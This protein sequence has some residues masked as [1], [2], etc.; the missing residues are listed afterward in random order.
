MQ[1]IKNWKLRSV[2]ICLSKVGLSNQLSEDE[3]QTCH[4]YIRNEVDQKGDKLNVRKAAEF[5]CG[6]V[7]KDALLHLSK[8]MKL[9]VLELE[10]TLLLQTIHNS[11]GVDEDGAG[12]QDAGT[13]IFDDD[14]MLQSIRN[15]Q[16]GYGGDDNIMLQSIRFLRNRY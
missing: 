15:S 9:V 1:K 12:K 11:I 3:Y 5:L 14:V 7:G 4:S 2:S 8:I 13:H 6:I 16:P 10:Q